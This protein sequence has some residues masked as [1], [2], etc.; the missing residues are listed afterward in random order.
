MKL[1]KR[2]KITVNDLLMEDNIRHI[3][4]DFLERQAPEASHIVLAFVDRAS[5]AV[6]VRHNS[7]YYQALGI[8]AEAIST[9]QTGE[10]V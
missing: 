2:K 9:M 8:L 4:S 1:D 7:T 6:F 10:E 3:V 5:G